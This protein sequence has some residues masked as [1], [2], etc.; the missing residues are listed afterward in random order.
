[1]KTAQ[2][3]IHKQVFL[4][5][6]FVTI[7]FLALFFF[8]D[9]IDAV[10]GGGGGLGTGGALL[11]VTMLV[12]GHLYELLPIAVLIGTI[13]VMSNLAQSSEFTILR[14][15]GLSPTRALRILLM[16]GIVFTGLTFVIG[17]YAAPYF[18]KMAQNYKA[19]SEGR[20]TVGKTGA[21]IKETHPGVNRIVNVRELTPSAEMRNIRIFNFDPAGNLSGMIK[22]QSGNFE[23]DGNW[24]LRNAESLTLSST[25][26][27]Q[28]RIEH[29]PVDTL[30]VQS[31]ISQGMVASSLLN[32]ERM[33]TLE[34]YTYMSHLKSNN[35]SA[36]LYEIQFWRNVFYPLS[37]LVMVMLALPFAYLHFRSGNITTSVFVGVVVGISYALLNNVFGYIGNLNGWIPWVAAAIPS[38]LYT[39]ISMWAFRWLV[40]KR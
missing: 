32:P 16:I 19:Q 35:Q 7:A 10:P 34:L 6:V 33:S 13:F 5:V 3:Y 4:S 2:R 17:D 21:W 18:N 28:Q 31:D 1:M 36:Q 24:T 39:A 8:F 29:Q 20:I 25:D 23:H 11:Y 12:P 26:T 14:T 30:T 38:L 9:A 37:C 27:A 40:L 22:A 15:S